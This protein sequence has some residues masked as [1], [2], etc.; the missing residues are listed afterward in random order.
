ML[1]DGVVNYLQEISRVL[2]RRGLLLR[3]PFSVE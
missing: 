2:R 3:Y 1:P